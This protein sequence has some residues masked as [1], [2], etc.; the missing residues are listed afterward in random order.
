MFEV[1]SSMT[2]ACTSPTSNSV[3]TPSPDRGAFEVKVVVESNDA[4]AA[5]QPVCAGIPIEQGRLR[6][7]VDLVLREAG[8]VTNSVQT[9]V[10][11]RWPDQSVKWL[12]VD[13]IAPCTHAGRRVYRLRA[14]T[15]GGAVERVAMSCQSTRNGAVIDTGVAVFTIDR[16]LPA[17]VARVG[18]AG[19]SLVSDDGLTLDLMDVRCRKRRGIIDDFQIEACGPIRTTVRLDGRFGGSAPCRWTARLS[20]FAG[21]G[22]MRLELTVHNPR[23]AR[24]RGGLW[25]LGDPGS[26]LFRELAVNMCLASAGNFET[27]WTVESGRS[28][29]MARESL[30]IYQDS[31]GG[32]NW[33]SRNHVD[34][35]GEIPCTF[36]GY[37]LRHGDVEESG[38]RAS[39]VVAI[40]SATGAAAVAIPEFWQQFPKAINAVGGRL[41]MGL[42]PALCQRP[43][44]VQGGEQKTHTIWFSFA[45]E[46]GRLIETLGWV[47]QP[48]RFGADSKEYA[49]S[50][51]LANL[52]EAAAAPAREFEQ[53]LTE[54]MDETRGLVARREI[55]DEYGWRNYGDLY[56]DHEARYYSGPKPIISHYNNQYDVLFGTLAHYLRTGN[57]QWWDIA[58]PLARH[59]IDIDLYRTSQDKSA[60][61]GGLFWHTD[62]YRD[63]ATATHRCYSQA[64]SKPDLSYGG[65]PCNEHN[66][67]T[68]LL[69]YYYLTGNPQAREAVVSLANWVVAMDEGRRSPLALL[70]GEATGMASGTADASFQG[71]GRG[72]GN[73]INALLDAWLLTN[74]TKYLSK[75][76]I[77]LRRSIH[78][79]D[80]LGERDLLNVESRW[81]YTVF[82]TVVARY[83]DLKA[84]AG[85][86]DACYAYAQ[87]ALLHYARWMVKHEV[88]YFD[89]PEKL[90]FP[91][92]TW[93]AQEM[94][95]ANVMRLAAAHA[96]E[97][98]R[99]TLIERG[100]AFAERAWTDLL[101]FAQP[102]TTRACAILLVEGWK[103][104]LYRAG[105]FQRAVRLEQPTDFG[106]PERFVP[107][108]SRIRERFRSPA[109]LLSLFAGLANPRRWV[110]YLSAE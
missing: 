93:A 28:P 1:S 22:L 39:P 55:I 10:L 23:R 59:V 33:Q 90:E 37:R 38:E 45:K 44:E 68:G 100:N 6:E 81:S 25:D 106:I 17:L 108:G 31:S 61:N 80:D 91:T 103:D 47:H 57:R 107:R 51:A 13:F 41:K 76:E 83:L 18:L 14:R 92:E 62:H 64:N 53:L 60:Y 78:P 110:N 36:R 26:I 24:H 94:R 74:E 5:P 35:T 21:S 85:H 101:R 54:V 77:L 86:L 40:G 88:H 16:T 9:E 48:A 97:P 46:L 87:A 3:E 89:A 15:A 70:D 42:F 50:R 19:R 63:A 20:F 104:A 67:T 2:A 8:G 30:E 95:K 7:P 32:A 43:H 98:L 66:Y 58:D 29:A 109:G 82:L 52:S 65:G 99:S 75:A 73:S 56:A 12:L 79:A 84:E 71:P 69:T 4:C 105:C 102:F 27:Q 72:C 49:K 34:R 96:D 11:A